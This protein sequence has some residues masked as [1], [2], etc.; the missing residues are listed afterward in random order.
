[1]T[2]DYFIMIEHGLDAGKHIHISLGKN[3]DIISV[4]QVGYRKVGLDGT[5]N[6]ASMGGH[7]GIKGP[8]E[9]VNR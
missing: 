1:M 7:Q 6:H 5:K 2:R 3:N 4:S 8:R 9:V